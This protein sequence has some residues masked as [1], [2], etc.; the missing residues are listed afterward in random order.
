MAIQHAQLDNL[1]DIRL[2]FGATTF[3]RFVEQA[4]EEAQLTQDE[5]CQKVNE[6]IAIKN[7]NLS[8]KDRIPTLNLRIYGNLVRHE[9][10]PSYEEFEP[11]Y[12]ALS[13]LLPEPF[14]QL[15]RV[16]YLELAQA[17]FEQRRRR[18][19]KGYVPTAFDWQTLAKTLASLDD[20]RI[21]ELIAVRQGKKPY[22]LPIPSTASQIRL[23]A[24]VTTLLKY[25]TSYVIE[26]DSYIDQM[27]Q[28]WE[29]GKRLVITKAISGTGKTRALYLL[30]KRIAR[31]QDRWP[32]YYTITQSDSQTPDDHLDSLLSLLYTDLQLSSSEDDRISRE[33]RMEQIFTEIIHCSEQGLRIAVLLD[34]AHILLD[35]RGN[36]TA[37]WQHFLDLWLSHDHKAILY[38]ATR[39]W[40]RWKG[41]NRNVY[42][43]TELE[44]LSPSGG[45]TIWQR[46]GFEDVLDP[47]LQD[48]SR[49][50]GGN[51]Q[52]IEMRASD[53][54]EPGHHFL[55]PRGMGTFTSQ[56]T[57]NRHTERIR[58]W[59]AKETIFDS[60]DDV[61]AR[62][63]LTHVFSRELP[64]EAQQ[65]LDLLVISPLGMPFML[66]EQNYKRPELALDELMRCSL[67]NRDSF[68][69]GRAML[70]SLAR[71][72]R[73][74][75]LS[76]ELKEEIE[77]QVANLY[78]SW[79]YDL[80]QY[81]DDGEQ[82]ALITEVVILYIKQ[83]HWLKAAELLIPYGWLCAQLGHTHRIERYVESMHLPSTLTIEQEAGSSLLKYR[84]MTLTG[85]KI[86]V[87]NRYQDYKNIYMHSHAGQLYLQP[88]TEIH[89]VHEMLLPEIQG[90][91]FEQGQRLLDETLNHINKSHHVSAEVLASWN[92]SKARLLA[93][94]SE[95]EERRE[96]YENALELKREC[97]AVIKETL[98]LWE[99]CLS[100][101]SPMQ[102]KVL[103]KRLGRS[104]NDYAYRQRL[105]GNIEEAYDAIKKC[106]VF[107][108]EKK[109]ARTRSLEVSR[110]EYA[111]ILAAMGMFIQADIEN[112]Q[113][114]EA[115]KELLQQGDTTVTSDIG[116]LLVERGDI[117]MKQA[118]VTEARPLYEEGIRLIGET[119]SRRTF[120]D[121]A[122]KQI[123]NIDTTPHYRLDA[124]WAEQY[125]QTA[126]YNDI[127]W[128][129]P[130]GPF[131]NEESKQWETLF[132]FKEDPHAKIRMD[133]ILL[134]SRQ[135]ELNMCFAEQREPR[136]HY[137]SIAIE[138]VNK[139][140]DE[141]EHLLTKITEQEHNVIVRKHYQARIQ[142]HLSILR[143]YKAISE[144]DGENVRK[145][146]Q[147][148]YGL[149]NK[150]EMEVAL[151]PLI[152]ML[153]KAKG[154][155]QV[156]PL[157]EDLL[158]LIRKWN[159]SIE[160]CL[161]QNKESEREK[162]AKQHPGAKEFE[163]KLVSSEIAKHFFEDIL[164]S[165][166]HFHDWRVEISPTRDIAHVEPH[167]HVFVLPNQSF[168]IKKLREL[169][170]EEVEMHIYRAMN[171]STSPFMLLGSGT[172]GY[173]ETEEALAIH[174]K[175][176]E[177]ELHKKSWL[178]TLATGLMAGVISPP[179]SFSDL[180]EFLEKSFQIRNITSE[181]YE[182]QAEAKEAARSDALDRAVRTVRGIP[183]LTVLGTCCL[184]DR[185]YLKGY[186]E[187]LDY[188]KDEKDTQNLLVGKIGIVDIQDMEQIHLLKPL[189]PHQHLAQNLD[190][191]AHLKKIE[192]TRSC[193]PEDE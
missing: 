108:Q 47:L 40:P 160:N 149:P 4:R 73:L 123:H 81:Q 78:T 117:L 32:C 156:S 185:G 35:E 58:T 115:L 124:Q 141:F 45:A 18:P 8:K 9:R 106:L 184:L 92:Q 52:L 158:G 119:S 168:S 170:A 177:Q 111:Q 70:V 68:E 23:S 53:L 191:Y 36:I 125:F 88:H 104:Y 46:F 11:I 80:Q 140:T 152:N 188:L 44:P 21:S 63:E 146:N 16:H 5:F 151:R 37:S 60:F 186:L 48:A 128:L 176:S 87:N 120:R 142:E 41:R 121:E 166:Y 147:K 90:T 162:Q 148:L 7:E 2:R 187:L 144:K 180:V 103:E 127:D 64:H 42:K 10:Y 39:E 175:S 130:A 183:D 167:L 131:S 112:A 179:F 94:W 96:N 29:Q 114:I 122:N 132:P 77:Q 105:L 6:Y 174:A 84:V 99:E 76:S 181:R 97:V 116:M 69:Q 133:E 109:A 139:H 3:G 155:S 15:E 33:E 159:V 101:A 126:S 95:T 157:V 91:H 62:E 89:I 169:L 93:R 55:W 134:Q 98:K 61:G 51:P 129:S 165:Y 59:L 34:D 49:K 137:P 164:Y 136:F 57:D 192:E 75:M 113:A 150:L 182:T 27:V 143:L 67:L 12:H 79:L 71:E 85:K 172:A 65:I 82:A 154:F 193:K 86:N 17:R 135:R 14:S 118:R 19:K 153:L 28:L 54:N 56:S 20:R 26:R 163:K 66:L 110:G 189:I 178:G 171:G 22:L 43:E 30:L 13:D 190:I 161:L 72:A 173:R 83:R 50:C 107:K 100:S 138:A 31:T 25:D 145:Y 102:Q 74:H 1:S 38:L 24:K